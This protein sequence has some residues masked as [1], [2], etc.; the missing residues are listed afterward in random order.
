MMAVVYYGFGMKGESAVDA[1]VKPKKGE[2]R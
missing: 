2:R 1:S